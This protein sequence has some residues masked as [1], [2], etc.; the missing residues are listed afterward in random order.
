[1]VKVL[2]TTIKKDE[3]GDYTISINVTHNELNILVDALN[4]RIHDPPPEQA[5]YEALLALNSKIFGFWENTSTSPTPIDPAYI[6]VPD[7]PC[8]DHATW[9]E[10]KQTCVADAGYYKDENGIFVPLPVNDCGANA[11]FDTQKGCICNDGFERDKFGNC[12]PIVIPPK[13]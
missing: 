12:V 4:F 1:M 7:M 8:P 2:D 9:D 13:P 10:N 6:K 5:E 3:T 11:H